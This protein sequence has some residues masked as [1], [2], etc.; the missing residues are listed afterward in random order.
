MSRPGLGVERVAI[1]GGT[2]IEFSGICSGGVLAH[3]FS[4]LEIAYL[5]KRAYLY[6]TDSV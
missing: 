3:L 5:K 2:T 1:S 6:V 4:Q